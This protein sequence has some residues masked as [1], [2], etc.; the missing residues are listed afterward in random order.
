MIAVTG[1]G[2]LR[3]LLDTVTPR[4]AHT[5]ETMIMEFP[6]Q[7]AVMEGS[8]TGVILSRPERILTHSTG[9]VA[10]AT[11]TLLYPRGLPIIPRGPTTLRNAGDWAPD[12]ARARFVAWFAPSSITQ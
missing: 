1:I 4:E 11:G 2:A 5:Q 12:Q 6:M 9:K 3:S 7:A 8:G 10:T